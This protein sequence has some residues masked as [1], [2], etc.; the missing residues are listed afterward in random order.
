MC[1]S[2]S[3]AEGVCYSTHSIA[4]I[5]EILSAVMQFAEKLEDARKKKLEDMIAA[6]KSGKPQGSVHKAAVP[7]KVLICGSL[8]KSRNEAR[9]ACT[10][11]HCGNFTLQSCSD[12]QVKLISIPY[13]ADLPKV[14][15]AAPVTQALTSRDT[16]RQSAAAPAPAK[17]PLRPAVAAQSQNAKVIADDDDA[18][19]Q[20][21]RNTKWQMCCNLAR[22]L[23]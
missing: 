15:Q 8:V 21:G 5:S 9:H 17:K 13:V 20:V 3:P 18:A 23:V 7:E 11:S 16:N 2:R 12:P 6:A 14:L 1:I 10:V 22:L 4:V 19:L